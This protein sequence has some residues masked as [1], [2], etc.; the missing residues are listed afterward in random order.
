MNNLSLKIVSP[1]EVSTLLNLAETTFRQSF[2]HLNDPVYFEAYMSE[3]FTTE[4]FEAELANPES[5][6]YFALLEGQIAGY[7]K[8][9]WGAAQTEIATEPGLE[10]QRIYIKPELQGRNIGRFLLDHA[11]Q[12]AK[13]GKFPFI[14]L[15]VWEKNERAIRFYERLGFEKFSSHTF[16]MGPDAQTDYLLKCKLS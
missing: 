15:G 6:F 11:F 10:L 4:Q 13:S 1:D 8:L 9:N 16:M 14:W 3:A 2:E 5:I 7:M 12:Y